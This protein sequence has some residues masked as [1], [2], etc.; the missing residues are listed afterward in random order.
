MGM[1]GD[2]PKLLAYMECMN[3]VV[4]SQ[5]WMVGLDLDRD[6]QMAISIFLVPKLL[7]HTL[8]LHDARDSNQV[9]LISGCDDQELLLIESGFRIL[10]AWHSSS[11]F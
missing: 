11:L 8:A 10:G 9:P 3:Y 6:D 7:C 5:G 4:S 1:R 2:S